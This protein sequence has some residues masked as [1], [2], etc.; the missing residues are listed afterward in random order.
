[1]RLFITKGIDWHHTKVLD[2]SYLDTYLPNQLLI[3]LL[4]LSADMCARICYALI[5]VFP[6][7]VFRI[8]R[9]LSTN[10][11]VVYTYLFMLRVILLGFRP[12]PSTTFVI[13]LQ[14]YWTLV[15]DYSY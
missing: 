10:V 6:S 12:V 11:S 3:P 9:F 2:T 15:T 1:M 8:C 7:A 5:E 13:V 4:V 14:E